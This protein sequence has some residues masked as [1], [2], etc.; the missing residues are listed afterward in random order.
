[1]NQRFFKLCFQT[2]RALIVVLAVVAAAPLLRA[3]GD[4]EDDYMGESPVRYAQ[5]K[6]LEGSVQIQKGDTQEA[7]DRGTPVAEGDVVESHGRGVLQLGDGSRVAFGDN[8]RFQVA[9]LFMDQHDERQVLLR[10]DYGRMRVTAGADSEARLRIDTPSGS[11]TLGDRCSAT[12]EVTS[13]RVTRVRVHTGRLAFSNEDNQTSIRAGERLTVYSGHDQLDRVRSFN[14]YDNDDFDNWCDRHLTVRRGESYT[15]VP[16]EIRYYSDDLDGNGEWTYVDDCS[17]WCWRP[18][19]LAE[20]W[21]PYWNGRWGCYAGGMTWVSDEPWGFV[22]HHY[23]RWGWRGGFG[24]YWIPGVYYSPAWVA[25]HSS[26][27]YFGWAPLGYRN[28][29]CS[30]GH[31]G[32]RGGHCWNVVQVNF[33]NDRH[34][35]NRV[36]SDPGVIQRFNPGPGSPTWPGA[37]HRPLTPPW[38]QGPLLVNQREFRNPT[39]IRPLLDDRAARQQRFNEYERQ[40]RVSTG[41]TVYRQ[42]P[43]LTRP[44][45]AGGSAAP[46]STPVASRAPFEDR[47][48]LR[49]IGRTPA[50]VSPFTRRPDTIVPPRPQ[51]RPSTPPQGQAPEP[52]R[53]F[54]RERPGNNVE[55]SPRRDVPRER[56]RVEERPQQ[57][58]PTREVPRVEPRRDLPREERRAPE[59][60]REER[61]ERRPDVS[62]PAPARPA[63]RPAAPAPAARPAEHAPAPSRSEPSRSREPESRR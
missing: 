25:W 30:W 29:P 5:V 44:L 12:F 50:S 55:Q 4:E 40:A 3:Q 58:Q 1:M 51:E 15:R 61:I 46:G 10:L 13:D 18:T 60:P 21:R 24:W 42:T 19:G 2:T 6:V 56:P 41:R 39:L 33:I 43:V 11:G 57:P 45:A 48:R 31:G 9:A 20:D 27:A 35:H 59:R 28:D 49:P 62:S 14:T 54:P 23:G 52:R 26:D 7:L 37:G 32:W 47:S 34:I 8:T 63:E 38:R 22:T 53:E 16:E 36:Y 17:S